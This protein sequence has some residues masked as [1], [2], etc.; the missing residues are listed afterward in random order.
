MNIQYKV[1]LP[2]W[3]FDQ[4][5]DKNHLKQLVLNYMARYPNYIVKSVKDGFAICERN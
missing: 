4:A 5:E 3:I 2:G 1:L